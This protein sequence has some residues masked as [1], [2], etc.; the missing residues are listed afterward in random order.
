MRFPATAPAPGP[1][2]GF[3]VPTRDG[4]A[5]RCP[6]AGPVPAGALGRFPV[7][8]RHP[9]REPGSVRGGT[10][11]DPVPA[12]GQAGAGRTETRDGRT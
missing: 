4:R 7:T 1:E 2:L 11:E 6:D 8:A 10:A 9:G 5:G 3:L 12:D